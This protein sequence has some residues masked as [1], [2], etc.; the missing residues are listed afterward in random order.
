MA[1]SISSNIVSL[2]KKTELRKLRIKNNNFLILIAYIINL[3]NLLLL[4]KLHIH[5]FF[6]ICRRYISIYG[7][8]LSPLILKM[9]YTL[10]TNTI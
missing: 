6:T 10:K 3:N 4:S 5:N 8:K 2:K 7:K 1:R 9:I